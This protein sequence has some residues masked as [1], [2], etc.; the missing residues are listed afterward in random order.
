MSRISFEL[1]EAL[2]RLARIMESEEREPVRLVSLAALK[3]ALLSGVVRTAEDKLEGCDDGS[4]V[5]AKPKSM[6]TND[7]YHC[8]ERRLRRAVQTLKTRLH[9]QPKNA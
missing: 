5:I 7:G 6:Q 4:C 8:D 3:I 2:A 9:L 1:G